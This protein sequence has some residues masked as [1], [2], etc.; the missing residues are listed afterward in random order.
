M[1]KDV[2]QTDNDGLFLYKSVAHE[3]PLTPGEFNVPYGAYVDEPPTPPAGKWP[4]RVGNV[5]IMIEDYR[6]TPLWV[7]ETGAPYS[8][9]SEHDGA[10]GKVSYPG[11]GTLPVW[12][13]AVEPARPV[14]DG[15]AD[16]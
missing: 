2:F 12:L 15:T 13:T 10:D 16:A 4:R 5:W 1:Q 6:T 11:W 7:V 8:L 14:D 3:L 9:G